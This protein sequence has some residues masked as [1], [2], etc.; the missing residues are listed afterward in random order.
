MTKLPLYW[1]EGT[2]VLEMARALL[3][4]II[5]T[6]FDGIRTSGRISE[7]EAYA[8]E[9]DR[10]SHCYGGRRTA[11]TEIM[12]GSGGFAY[13]YLCYG[14]HHLFNVVTNKAEMPQVVLIRAIEP[15]EGIG[16][17][18]ERLGKGEQVP[19]NKLA[20]GPGL[21][22]KALGIRTTHTG[23]PLDGAISIW[24]DGY[25]PAGIVAG[26]RIGIDYAKED[27]DLPYRFLYNMK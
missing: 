6:E 11:R 1:F 16:F 18:R 4:K 10:A 13:V 21:V 3:G 8:G 26:P 23:W 19:L 15:V 17:I 12:Y 2:D 22:T 14:I 5:V 27:K 24:D 20:G 9:S 7:T 25:K